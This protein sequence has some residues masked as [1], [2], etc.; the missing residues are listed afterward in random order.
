MKEE[1][2]KLVSDVENGD[3]NPLEALTKVK[4][5]EDLVKDAKAKISEDA[6]TEYEKHGEKTVDIYGYEIS[7]TASGRYTY[8]NNNDWVNIDNSRKELEKKM[9]AAY[10]AAMTMLDE[11]TGEMI[12]AAEYKANKPSL[13]LKKKK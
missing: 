4:E 13:R 2:L 5:L 12:P 11:A 1:I 6:I 7:Y 8:S 3:I 10:K 9:Q